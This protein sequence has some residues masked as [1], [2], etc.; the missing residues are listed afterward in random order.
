MIYCLTK[1]SKI[2]MERKE[3]VVYNYE[4]LLKVLERDGAKIT[5]KGYLYELWVIDNKGKIN[6]IN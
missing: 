4:L 3:K 6:V 2:K 1:I 5:E